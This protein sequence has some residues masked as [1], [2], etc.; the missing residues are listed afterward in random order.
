MGYS[1]DEMYLYEYINEEF[2]DI[3]THTSR[4][5][6]SMNSESELCIKQEN[7]IEPL[8]EYNPVILG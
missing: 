5:L 4:I 7:Y 8:D 1:V 2:L 3:V 6:Y